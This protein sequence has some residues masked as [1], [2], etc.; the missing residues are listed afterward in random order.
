MP[1]ASINPTHPRTN[2]RNFHE[3][4]LRIGE[5]LKMT[6]CLLF[7]FWLL[8]CSK[9]NLCVFSQW[10]TPRRF[11]WGS[12][13]FWWF[14]QNLEKGCIRTNMHTTVSWVGG[15]ANNLFRHFWWL[16]HWP[17]YSRHIATCFHSSKCGTERQPRLATF[18]TQHFINPPTKSIWVVCY[19]ES[20]EPFQSKYKCGWFFHKYIVQPDV[21]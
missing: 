17:R 15:L 5:A 11:I 12:V 4:I 6:F 21:G 8:G 18:W 14:L 7:D 16:G 1:F 3:K 19:I 2:L 9:K 13:Y 10:K 20:V